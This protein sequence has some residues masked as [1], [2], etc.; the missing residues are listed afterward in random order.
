[1]SQ[2]NYYKCNI[3][4]APTH[5]VAEPAISYSFPLD[6]FQEHAIAALDQ[7]HNVLVCAKTGSGKT[8]VAE[9]GIADALKRGKR[10]FYT[11]PIKSLSNQKFHDL[12]EMYKGSAGL[13]G[14]APSA[15]V[16]IMTG[17]I[18]Y[19]PQAEIVVMTTE[20]LRNLLYKVGTAT[21][22]VGL[23]AALSMNHVGCVVFDECHY[24]N[25]KDRGAVWEES[26]MLL[27]ADVRM[28]LL[29]AT[30]DRPETFADWL[31]EIKG[32]PCALIQT[33][34]RV[35]PLTHYVIGSGAGAGAGAGTDEDGPKLIPIMD[36]RENFK[37]EVYKQ[38]TRE[39]KKAALDQD[40]YREKVKQ[41]KAAG[42]EGGIE[43][44]IAIHSF[45]HTLNQTVELL[46]K[47]DLLPAV[48]FVFSR[49]DCER[50]AALVDGSVHASVV[51]PE[52]QEEVPVF[53]DGQL[54]FEK[55]KI[56]KEYKGV[57]AQRVFDFHLRRHKK[58]LE[59]LPVYHTLREL[60]GR[61]LGFHHSGLLPVLKEVLEL[62]YSGGY[63][64]L[65]FC[66]ETFAVGL[67]MPTRT[68]LFTG[69]KKY[70]DDCDG[71]RLLRNDEYLQM[72]G[73]AGRRG[74]D[75]IGYVIYVPDRAPL[76]WTEVSSILKGSLPPLQS[77]MRF[78]Y[79]FLLKILN[80]GGS[81][82]DVM[83]RSYWY[84]CHD[85]ARAEAEVAALQAEAAAVACKP[86]AELLA[87]LET[88][89]GW[90]SGLKGAGNSE[91]KALQRK[92]ED[93]RNKHM[94]PKWAEAAKQFETYKKA[95]AVHE[96]A[97]TVLESYAG[98]AEPVERA[99]KFL[100]AHGYID[101]ENGALTRKGQA[102]SECNESHAL[103]ATALFYSGKLKELSLE[104][105]IG[106]CAVFVEGGKKDDE[107]PLTDVSMMPA[108]MDVYR[109]LEGARAE[110]QASEVAHF[111][112]ADVDYWRLYTG[113]I[114]PLREWAS[115]GPSG[116]AA[117]GSE[118]PD[119]HISALCADYGIFE[120][121]F[122]R[123]VLKVAN[124]LDELC[125]LATLESDTK[126]LETLEG[127]RARLVRDVVVPDSLY[128]HL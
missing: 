126:L 1:M 104:D 86:A 5:K 102:A 71:M 22:H 41:L 73:R 83:R 26:M 51:D 112:R 111:L 70:S 2:P 47:D 57:E 62:L 13:A 38:W 114:A 23:T 17:D 65:L 119:I 110:F 21:E 105:I 14:T 117:S 54:V 120:G 80:G 115:S 15:S 7:G 42:V 29:S 88:F 78:G 95:R 33:G 93:W 89:D 59:T 6:P 85:A 37:G 113:M 63:L 79:E 19:N 48:C 52:D 109:F 8:L 98:Y 35:V 20:I 124:V 128:L 53:K 72:A 30:L 34:Y 32:V 92:I 4:S 46:K 106:V 9:Y 58:S 16:G 82:L 69:L 60:V 12:T 25:D 125:A 87:D 24:I 67:N 11:T 76:D 94:G 116:A 18:K 49:K 118:E 81:W 61:G 40:K 103:L 121:N 39:H 90:A 10:V 27:P 31:G 56:G 55:A 84:R 50:Y 101:A 107:P 108:V 100:T 97:A 36:A 64:K 45:T 77:T 123:S 68:V 74:K 75:T 3:A 91:R 28:V 66:T 122:V 99:W 44:K 96:R 43:G 127:A